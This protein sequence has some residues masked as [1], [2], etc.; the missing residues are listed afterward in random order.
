M[1]KNEKKNHLS[2]AV[3]LSDINMAFDSTLLKF[4]RSR[5]FGILAKDHLFVICQH[6]KKDFSSRTTWPMSLKSHMQPPGKMGKQV[7]IFGL[8]HST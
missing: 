7:Y 3:V 2:S 8:G 1:G 5:S 6:F 4:K